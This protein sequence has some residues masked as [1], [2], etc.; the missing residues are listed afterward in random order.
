M[1]K[2]IKKIKYRHGYTLLE[3]IVSICLI[4]MVLS[5]AIPNTRIIF[6]Q[7]EK[8]ELKEFK[9]DI[10]YARNKAILENGSYRININILENKYTII[11]ERDGMI[12]IKDKE[13]SSGIVLKTTNFKGVLKFNST[14]TTKTA[15]EIRL[16]NRRGQDIRITI[17]PVTSKISL[18]I[19]GK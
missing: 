16:T 4:L 3:M 1:N 8:N 6:N 12:V 18:K 14:G 5:I 11:D 2:T 19:E 9:R 7:R 10:L 13:F 15:G 17:T